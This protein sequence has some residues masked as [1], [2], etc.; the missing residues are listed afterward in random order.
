MENAQMCSP[1][2]YQSQEIDSRTAPVLGSHPPRDPEL[3]EES[4]CAA[5]RMRQQGHPWETARGSGV[6]LQK[7][8]P[9]SKSGFQ[10]GELAALS[11]S[12]PAVASGLRCQVGTHPGC[13]ST[14]GSFVGSP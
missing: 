14:G 2:S 11:C 6:S 1:R 3:C 8:F 4:V 10:A 9:A 13:P 5:P 7:E 12:P